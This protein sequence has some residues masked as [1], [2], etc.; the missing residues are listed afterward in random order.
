M[1]AA[2][3]KLAIPRSTLWDRLKRCGHFGITASA[4]SACKA[5]PL[6]TSDDD[7]RKARNADSKLSKAQAELKAERK[8]RRQ[9]E[10]DLLEATGKLKL[11]T[12]T[13]K[14]SLAPRLLPVR[15]S[16][17]DTATAVI[18][19]VDWHIGSLVP[20]AD[21]GG[22]NEFNMAIASK[23][24]RN[25]WCKVERMIEHE[26]GLANIDEIILW[27]G[28][29]LISGNIHPELAETNE[30]GITDCI[31]FVQSHVASGL[32][33]LRGITGIER[34]IVPTSRGNHGRSTIDRRVHGN[35]QNSFEE[36]MYQT[37]T[38]KYSGKNGVFFVNTPSPFNLMKVYDLS[39]RF[40][41][42]DMVR[43]QGGVL[44]VSVPMLKSIA[45]WDRNTSADMTFVGHYHQA[46]WA[47]QYIMSGSLI[48]F[49]QYAQSIGAA[50]E[51]P[52]QQFTVVSEKRGVTKSFPLFVED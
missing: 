9:S 48:G 21:V 3:K 33:Q 19:C 51:P 50:C 27:L 13:A 36:I 42:G 4:S 18:S 31:K 17:R 5:K 28:G 43:Y 38:S 45:K 15:S 34:V 10:A 39:C 16:S 14:V 12:Q 37:L 2:A 25:L 20:K 40:T 6:L 23:R 46:A 44:G 35:D 24:I 7:V 52:S 1:T 26:R 11:Y 22:L 49:D 47:K 30:A 41:H 8:K 32:Q 29:D